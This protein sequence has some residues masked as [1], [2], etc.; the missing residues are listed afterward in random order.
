MRHNYGP[1]GVRPNAQRCPIETILVV[2][3]PALRALATRLA[4]HHPNILIAMDAAE[5]GPAARDTDQVIIHDEN[6]QHLHSMLARNGSF[7]N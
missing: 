4:A 5:M 2:T 3:D 1:Y 7:K 6:L